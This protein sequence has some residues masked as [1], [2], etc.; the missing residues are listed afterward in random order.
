MNHH[1]KPEA[2]KLNQRKRLP[3]LG[4]H[5]PVELYQAVLCWVAQ[6]PEHS[7]AI[8]V[9]EAARLKLRADGIIWS[10]NRKGNVFLP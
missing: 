10:E 1:Q 6:D 9:R 5:V 2:S 8:F 3:L 4:G 7:I